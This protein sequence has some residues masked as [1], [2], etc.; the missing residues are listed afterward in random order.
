MISFRCTSPRTSISNLMVHCTKH[1]AHRCAFFSLECVP[2]TGSQVTWC[3]VWWLFASSPHLTSSSADCHN[4]VCFH[5]SFVDAINTPNTSI[6]CPD[7]IPLILDALHIQN[8]LNIAFFKRIHAFNLLNS[9]LQRIN[10]PSVL[11]YDS[12]TQSFWWQHSFWGFLCTFISLHHFLFKRCT[13]SVW[14]HL[15][16]C[17]SIPCGWY[18][19]CGESTQ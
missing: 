2:L 11:L 9:T 10:Y 6:N 19:F 12:G 13:V 18:T 17:D 7:G 15:A 1:Q 16:S 5:Y 8:H 3:M 14:I 4:N